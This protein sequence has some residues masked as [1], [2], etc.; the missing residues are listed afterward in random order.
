I[1]EEWYCCHR[2]SGGGR[3]GGLRNG[4]KAT[5]A[6]GENT[7]DSTSRV[8]HN[9][10]KDQVTPGRSYRSAQGDDRRAPLYLDST[11]GDNRYRRKMDESQSIASGKGLRL[12]EGNFFKKRDSFR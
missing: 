7:A 2:R 5:P 12:R 11:R 8:G 6:Y 4:V 1:S 10:R 9:R 3:F